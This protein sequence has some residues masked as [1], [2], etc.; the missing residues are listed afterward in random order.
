MTTIEDDG[1][2]AGLAVVGG[3]VR[4]LDMLKQVEVWVCDTGATHHSCNSKEGAI[5]ERPASSSTLGHAGNAVKEESI[6]DLKGQFITDDG[7][8][9][10]VATLT[11]VSVNQK[12]NFNLFSLTR[13]LTRGWH[14]ARGDASSIVIEDK[15]GNRIVFD[16][17]IRTARGAIYATRFIRETSEVSAVGTEAGTVMNINKAHALLGHSNEDTVRQTAKHLG[18]E[19]TRGTMRPKPCEECAKSKARQKAL[20]NGKKKTS[21]TSEL[22]PGDLIYLDLSKVTAAK[23]D[24]SEDDI[25][26][27]HCEIMV[28]R[29][30]GKKWINFTS[31]KKG[32][33]EPTCEWMNKMKSLGTPIRAIRMD[34]GGENI[35]L[36]KRLE[37]ADWQSLQPVDVQV[38]SRDTPQHNSRVEVSFP[39]IAGLARANLNAAWIPDEMRASLVIEAMR[40]SV[41]V[42][43]LVMV[44]LRGELMT[45]EEHVFGKKPKWV[46]NM[47]IWGEA[48]VVKTGKDKKTGNR[49]DTMMFVGYSDRE[50]DSCRMFDTTTKR[51]VVTRDI[52]WLGRMYYAPKP[53]ESD[54]TIELDLNEEID[55]TLDEDEK[56]SK[57]EDD[58]DDGDSVPDID[59]TDDVGD[60][61]D[62]ESVAGEDDTPVEAPVDATVTTSRSGRALQAPS[63]LIETMSAMMDNSPGTLASL[64]Y[65]QMMAEVDEQEIN[66]EYSMMSHES[67]LNLV[68]AGIVGGFT[69]VDELRV[70]NYHEAMAGEDSGEWKKEVVNEKKK[71]DKFN[72][73]TPVKRSELPANAKILETTWAMKLKANGNRRARLNAKGFQQRDGMHYYSDSIYSP[74]TNPVAIRMVLTLM[75]MNPDYIA[76]VVDV[77]GAFL[78]GKFYDGEEIYIQIPSGF[79]PYYE[80][81]VVL[82][83]NVPIYGTKQASHCFYKTFVKGLV[84]SGLYERSKAQPCMFFKWIDERLVLFVLWTDDVLTV[85][86]PNH[87]KKVEDDIM[88]TFESKSEGELSEYV[89]NKIDIKRSNDGRATVK[90]TQP[91]LMEKLKEA[92]AEALSVGG[93][94]PRTPAVE[95]QVLVRGDGSGELGREDAKQYRSNVALMNY[96]SQWSRPEILNSVRGMARHMQLPRLVHLNAMHT[97][98][99]Y[100]VATESRGWTLYPDRT[101]DGSKEFMFRIGGRADSNYAADTDDRR[102]VS[103]G[104][105]FLNESP[106]IV[107]SNTQR[108][109]S[110]SVTEAEQNAGVVVAQDM[111]YLMQTMNAVGLK[112]ELPMVLEMDNIG[113]VHQA[114]NMSVGG[115]TRHVDVKSHFLRELKEEGLLVIKHISGDDN[116]SDIFTKNT[117]IKVFERHIPKFVGTDEYMSSTSD[118]T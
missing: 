68:G 75:A 30:T 72:A 46:D 25:P 11:E 6:I 80:D 85:G 26:R 62:D 96:M 19:I 78:Q 108:T 112:V 64:R 21:D 99:R 28:D 14:I 83:L 9:G 103:G 101:W 3:N 15:D 33:V 76:S 65:L 39:Y 116:D 79:E 74:V 42:D 23:S 114:N 13:L 100:L 98:T 89:G 61:A 97:A 49:G 37:S 50:S 111:I 29:S 45:R 4:T 53:V 56:E 59:G 5:N 48:G 92:N 2:E 107:R 95:G 91:V 84:D 55:N 60:N 69:S 71:F 57:E 58:S 32:M 113:A 67:E 27:K 118:N 24:G 40:Y 104:R 12:Y 51:V 88:S 73:I 44:E 115:R 93:A 36:K 90:F 63:R 82:R 81:D 16:I 17:V 35:K 43:C 47:R 38:T 41:Q 34:P 110:L 7:E 31:T 106:V 87:V 66:T 102:S 10:I 22:K 70:M 20:G 8:P 117:S 77:E 54:V 86:L 52:I 94:A 18:W 109:V 105:A 1:L